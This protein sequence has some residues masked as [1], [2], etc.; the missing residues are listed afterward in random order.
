MPEKE[1]QQKWKVFQNG[2]KMGAKTEKKSNENE[3]WKSM[4]K[5][6]APHPPRLKVGR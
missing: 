6:D 4:R 1:M 2:A 5:R 3:V